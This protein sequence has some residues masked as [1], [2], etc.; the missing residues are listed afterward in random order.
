MV[1]LNSQDQK[2]VA[3]TIIG[4]KLSVRDTENLV[5]RLKSNSQAKKPKI[6]IKDR[7]NLNLLKDLIE[8]FGIKCKI[9]GP[10]LTLNLNDSKK[11]ANLIKIIQKIQ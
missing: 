7:E 3:D 6:D 9:N 10:K 2:L 5:K 4:Q 8:D 11:I 1:G